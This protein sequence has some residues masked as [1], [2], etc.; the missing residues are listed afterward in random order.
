MIH[1]FFGFPL[2]VF[3]IASTDDYFDDDNDE[4]GW[5]WYNSRDEKN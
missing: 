5:I 4:E 3:L 1:M 2:V